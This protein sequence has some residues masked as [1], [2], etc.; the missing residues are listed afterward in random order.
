ML[1]RILGTTTATL[2]LLPILLTSCSNPNDNVQDSVA[3]TTTAAAVVQDTPTEA[4]ET[5]TPAPV[6]LTLLQGKTSAFKLI[7]SDNSSNAITK[8]VA[9]MLKTIATY[10][11]G[12]F[13]LGTDWERGNPETVQNDNAEILI[14]QTNRAES[15]EVL[16]T[17][18]DNSYTVTIKNNKLVIIG[19]DDNMTILA[20]FDF[21]ERILMNTELCSSGKLV[22]SEEDCFTVTRDSKFSLSEM[23]QGNYSITSTD[24]RVITC[25]GVDQYKIGQGAASDGTYAYFALRNSGDTGSV[26]CK[27]RLD[28]GTF[29]AKSDVLDLGHANDMTFDTAKNQLV[30]AHGQ[31][32]GKIITIVDPDTLKFVK[33]INITH[34]SGAITYSVKRGS[35]AISQGGSTLHMMSAD[36]KHVK[37]YSRITGTGYTAQG[38]GSDED[39]IYFPMSGKND[40]ILQVYDWDGNYVT[41]ITIPIDMESESLFW[42]NDTYYIAFNHSGSELLHR[43]DFYIIYQQPDA[44][45]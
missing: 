34:G 35:Y 32:E 6:S 15:I 28:D 22:I 25:K 18:P 4:P 19:T 17:L 5:T 14:G 41:T 1:K 38:M 42:V 27:Y 37:S 31:S 30:V 43:I 24:K 36:L 12:S 45:N 29:V 20:L 26:I 13:S 3:D 40:N 39:Y 23:I 9:N 11:E 33:D 7:R 8:S 10:T 44:N 21:A 2:L 16:S